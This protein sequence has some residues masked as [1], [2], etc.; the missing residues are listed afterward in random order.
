MSETDD[1]VH[2]AMDQHRAKREEQQA[3]YNSAISAQIRSSEGAG[4]LSSVKMKAAKLIHSSILDYKH[5]SPTNLKRVIG[6][7]K[8]CSDNI[9]DHPEDPKYR[10]V[11]LT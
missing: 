1:T 7:L 4:S 2:A 5:H 11:I 6:M 3:I 10:R 8:R 9:L